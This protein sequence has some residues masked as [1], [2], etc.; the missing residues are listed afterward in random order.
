MMAYNGFYW[1]K[2]NFDINNDIND[3]KS[4]RGKLYTTDWD[5]KFHKKQKKMFSQDLEINICFHISSEIIWLKELNSFFS[6]KYSFTIVYQEIDDLILYTIAKDV[7][8][9]SVTSDKVWNTKHLNYFFIIY[10]TTI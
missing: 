2:I 5:D 10:Q 7:N 9:V 1:N 8:T 3:I 6:E 4:L